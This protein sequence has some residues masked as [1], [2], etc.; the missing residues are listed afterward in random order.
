[1][2]IIRVTRKQIEEAHKAREE[3][4]RSDADFRA[5]EEQHERLQREAAERLL[6]KQK[7]ERPS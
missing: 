2:P 3:A 1:M 5:H 6:E 4:L 7:K